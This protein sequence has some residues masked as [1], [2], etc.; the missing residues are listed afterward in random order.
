[1]TSNRWHNSPFRGASAESLTLA[2]GPGGRA[3]V[4]S[5]SVRSYDRS[6]AIPG[7]IASQPSVAEKKADG[8]GFV[9]D[10]SGIVVTNRHVVADAADIIVTLHDGTLLRATVLASATHSDLA[11]LKIYAD[12]PLPAVQFGNSDAVRPGDRVMV[13]GNPLGLAGTVTR[14]ILSALDRTSAESQS[15][16]FM[17]IDAALR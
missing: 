8:S 12:R 7:N 10:A 14:G 3:Q 6:P 5:L 9:V 16:S 4:V 15:D 1:M 17:Q 13:I 2:V 11:L